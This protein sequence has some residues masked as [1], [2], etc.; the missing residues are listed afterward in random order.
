MLTCV[1]IK[2]CRV[3]LR[4]VSSQLFTLSPQRPTSIKKVQIIQKMNFLLWFFFY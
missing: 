3:F 1:E 4:F 2:A